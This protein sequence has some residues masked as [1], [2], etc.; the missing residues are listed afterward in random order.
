VQNLDTLQCCFIVSLRGYSDAITVVEWYPFQHA[1]FWGWVGGKVVAPITINLRFLDMISINR[2]PTNYWTLLVR[3]KEFKC[4]FKC[5]FGHYEYKLWIFKEL[6]TNIR[7]W[8]SNVL[9]PY[10]HLCNH[11]YLFPIILEVTVIGI[12]TLMGVATLRASS[13]CPIWKHCNNKFCVVSSREQWKLGPI[14]RTP[15]SLV[16][17]MRYFMAPL[18]QDL[19]LCCVLQTPLHLLINPWMPPMPFRDVWMN[20]RS[21]GGWLRAFFHPFFF[22]LTFHGGLW[23]VPNW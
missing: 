9:H 2:H 22:L 16:S 21:S 18:W 8:F 23:R 12:V 14:Q 6:N 5:I 13:I 3:G 15:P 19:V 20:R 4:T 11:I 1:A 7:V 10:L 17:Q